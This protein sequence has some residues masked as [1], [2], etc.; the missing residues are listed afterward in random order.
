MSDDRSKQYHQIAK[1]CLKALNQATQ[2]KQDTQEKIQSVYDAIDQ[3]FK[4]TF[5][6][7]EKA[8]SCAHRA[9]NQISQLNEDK[10]S[11]AKAIKIAKV[12]LN[13]KYSS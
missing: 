8:L 4:E 12:A 2:T 7:H 5:E 9:L 3:A 13:G 6:E 11:T 1:A 10:D